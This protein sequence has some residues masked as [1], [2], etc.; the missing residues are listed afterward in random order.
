MESH[1]RRSLAAETALALLP[2]GLAHFPAAL[3][4]AVRAWAAQGT[5]VSL[6]PLPDNKGAG[7]SPLGGGTGRPPAAAVSR[8]Q[9][10]PAPTRWSRLPSVVR[11]LM[12]R[13]LCCV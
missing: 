6:S 9:P 5:P 3:A 4:L 12:L 11:R 2:G 1:H 7:P 13:S 8:G 10:A